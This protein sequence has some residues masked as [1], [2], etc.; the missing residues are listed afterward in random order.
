VRLSDE[1]K[2][3]ILRLIDE[4]ETLD[5]HDLEA[6]YRWIDAS[7]EALGFY[8]LHKQRFDQYCRSSAD[9]YAARIYVGLWMLRLALDEASSVCQQN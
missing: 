4:G 9:T 5:V 2:D 3:H 7:Y 1:E 8:P 6:L